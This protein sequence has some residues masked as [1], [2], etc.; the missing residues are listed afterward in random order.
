MVEIWFPCAYVP[1][2][3][4]TRVRFPVGVRITFLV[5]FE[6][7]VRRGEE[8]FT[9]TTLSNAPR[10]ARAKIY[11]L[12]AATVDLRPPDESW[13]QLIRGNCPDEQ[14]QYKAS[15]AILWTA[16]MYSSAFILRF[17]V[18]V[19]TLPSQRTIHCV[20]IDHDYFSHAP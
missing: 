9:D 14:L 8:L 19:L 2:T 10:D 18:P 13:A 17:V 16:T 1:A 5:F 4:E 20:S 12:H 3:D 7:F 15:A 11:G 6:K